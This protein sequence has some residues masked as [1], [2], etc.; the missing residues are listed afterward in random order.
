MKALKKITLPDAK[1]ILGKKA[2]KSIIG[3]GYGNNWSCTAQ[4]HNCEGT[5]Y[6]NCTAQYKEECVI[7]AVDMCTI[8]INYPPIFEGNAVISWSCV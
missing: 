6:W 3:G 7:Y 1:D 4:C 5:I 8:C 2:Q